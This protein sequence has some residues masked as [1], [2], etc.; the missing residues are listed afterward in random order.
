MPSMLELVT[1][2]PKLIEGRTRELFLA[3]SG[4]KGSL[5]DDD[6]ISALIGQLA[7]SL[8]RGDG[9]MAD[10][11][12]KAAT[13]YGGLV[14]KRGLT[15]EEL[16]RVYGSIREA[17]TTVG[18]EIN[19]SFSSRDFEVL[20]RVLDTAI[21]AS[22]TEYQ[23]QKANATADEALQHI[24][25][26]AHELRTTLS[27]AVITF[28]VIKH[29]VVGK[30]RDTLDRS[31]KRM[32]D[33]I[34]RAMAEVRLRKDPAPI[35]ESLQIAGV[36]EEI[37]AMFNPEAGARRQSL[38]IEIDPDLEIV[39]DRQIF[40]SA[41][42]NLVQNGLKYTP[43]DGHIYLRA[44]SVDDRLVVEVEDECGGLPANVEDAL[45]VPFVRGSTRSPGTGLG[46][47]IVAR[48]AKTLGGDVSARNLPG[49]GCIFTIEL[50]RRPTE[51]AAA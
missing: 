43:D 30:R 11:V 28:S 47:S 41:V 38:E 4:P 40:F 46:L 35:M 7:D 20:N 45:F 2:H 42:S 8:R 31:L 51:M 39:T 25:A 16:V 33:L 22:V 27:A 18:R 29:G 32:A 9:P 24:G 5:R 19:I 3:V 21:S 14:F 1:D 50:S 23:R 48:A 37:A 6:D 26:L 17:V 36:F 12:A 34:D 44:R 15:V 13:S 10:Q 49:K